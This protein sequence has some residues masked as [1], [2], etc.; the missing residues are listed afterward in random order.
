MIATLAFV[1][2]VSDDNNLTAKEKA[3]GWQLLFDGKSTAGWHNFK[4]KGVK[5]GW[6]VKN[7]VLT[8]VS[9]DDAGDICTDKMFTY[10]E[11]KI[12]YRLTKGGNSGVMFRVT[13]DGD[14]TWHSGPEVQIYD[15]HGE[16]GAQKSGFLYELYGSKVDSTVPPGN[17]NT[18]VIHIAKDKCYTEVNGKRYY[19]FKI[20]SPDF[21]AKVKASKFSEHPM[22]AK[23]KTGM[24]AIQGDHGVVSFKNI[25]IKELKS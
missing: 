10:F 24:I 3:A 9:P 2:A 15:D 6:E 4:A 11:L 23:S 1:L 7:G 8:S 18:F 20:D 21:W 19:E 14:E 13:N 25:K 17:W 22:F 16:E 5:P 12:D